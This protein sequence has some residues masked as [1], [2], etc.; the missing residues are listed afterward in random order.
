MGFAMVND[1]SERDFEYLSQILI[2]LEGK[3]PGTRA[4]EGSPFKWILAQPSPTKGSIG[5]LLV[6]YWVLP[7][8]VSLEQVSRENQIYLRIGKSLIQVKFSTLWD[9]GLYRF[10]QIRDR[11]YDFCLCL[12]LAPNDMNVWL[13]PKD[14]LDTHVI[15]TKG[16]H[17]GAGSG[18]TWWFEVFPNTPHA[19]LEECGGQ[20]ATVRSRLVDLNSPG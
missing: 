20:L 10:Q 14:L 3:Y 8:G 12:G 4:W 11:G 18:E 1:A 15:G 2:G 19:W 9:T 16:Q 6:Q 17:T 7:Y 13:I 5:R